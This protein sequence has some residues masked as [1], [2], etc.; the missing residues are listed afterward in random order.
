[1]LFTTLDNKLKK[2]YYGNKIINSK[3]YIDTCKS[4]TV[5]QLRYNQFKL[6]LN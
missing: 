4:A 5:K 3:N 1:M 6:A 2:E